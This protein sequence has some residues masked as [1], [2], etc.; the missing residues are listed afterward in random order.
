MPTST[1][2][3]SNDSDTPAEVISSDTSDSVKIVE[4]DY[5]CLLVEE[6][7]KPPNH[8]NF[9]QTAFIRESHGRPIFGV[10]FNCD[11]RSSSSDPLLFATVGA[12][13]VTIYQCRELPPPPEGQD[14]T[15]N[16]PI[17]LLQSFSDASSDE[18]FYCCA[19]SCNLD[20]RRGVAK[21]SSRQQILAVAGKRGVIRILCPSLSKCLDSLIGH[22]QAVNELKFHPN[23]PSL[24]F[25]FSKDFTVRLW[26]IATHVM[27][28]IFGGV[29]GHRAEVLHGD[30]SLTGDFLL[31][32]SMDHTIKI[33]RLDIPEMRNAVRASFEYT[34]KRKPFHTLLQHFPDFSTRDAHG[35]YVDCARWFGSLVISKSCENAVVVWMPGDIESATSPASLDL[36]DLLPPR[37]VAID[38]SSGRGSGARA[39]QMT[40]V[41]L[42]THCSLLHQLRLPDCDL[43]YVRFDLHLQQ[44]LLALGTGVGLPRIFLWDLSDLG[45]TLS[46][47]PKVL[48]ITATG[49]GN[50][51]NFG[52]IRQTRFTG[53]GRILVAVG[54]NGLVVRFD[55]VG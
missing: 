6:V 55:R 32:A 26:N 50:L 44:R 9:A 42:E 29:E 48:H 43:W 23:H 46:L 54:D 49:A 41:P 11:N 15:S 20:A 47:V 52:A 53:D 39:R 1:R 24:L 4:E 40:G 19:W 33:W 22:G 21:A 34:D 51:N 8:F 7:G 27:V 25:S 28:C 18:E 45:S 38:N 12:N 30:I 14:A 36:H 37:L 3:P 31:T 35:N 2:K 5:D 10:A 16:P 17:H 13:H